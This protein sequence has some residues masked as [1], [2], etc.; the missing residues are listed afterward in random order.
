MIGQF[1]H[2]RGKIADTA[3]RE[4]GKKLTRLYLC[5]RDEYEHLL[6]LDSTRVRT[7]GSFEFRRAITPNSPTM[8]H[9]ITGFDNGEI[10]F[11]LEA[12]E[13]SIV[14][15]KAA[16]PAAAWAKGTPN[17]E[18]MAQYRQLTDR[19]LQVQKDS[20]EQLVHTH[21]Q[22]WIDSPEGMTTRLRIGAAALLD[23]NAKRMQFLLEHADAPLTP[24]MMEKEIMPLL[25][26]TY[27]DNLLKCISPTLHQ[28]PY[29]R[30][31]YN[32]VQ[33]TES[34]SRCALAQY[35][36]AYA[37]WGKKI[38]ER[39]SGAICIARF[40]GFVVRSLFA[41]TTHTTRHSRASCN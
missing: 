1:C 21:G 10:P 9:F 13:V 25:D 19:C 27:A 37:R 41:R 31:F 30:S 18:L 24:L 39:F 40:L 3:L 29:Y 7:D 26:K 16:Y 17:N 33:D 36:F 22:Q 14:L 4:E 32:A 5:A 11:F 23:C 38:L 34:Q 35:S 6:L 2:I 15:S 28:H 12:G 8:L 20:L